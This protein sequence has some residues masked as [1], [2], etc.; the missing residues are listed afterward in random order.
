MS[1]LQRGENGAQYIWLL[2]CPLSLQLLKVLFILEQVDYIELLLI[3]SVKEVKWC[4]KLRGKDQSNF[5]EKI[6]LSCLCKYVPFNDNYHSHCLLLLH[7][8]NYLFND[9]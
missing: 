5:R 8:I 4:N 3:M 7:Y 9:N 6:S 1:N 2:G